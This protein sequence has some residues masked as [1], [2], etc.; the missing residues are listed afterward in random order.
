MEMEV[1]DESQRVAAATRVWNQLPEYLQLDVLA[2]LP[3]ETMEIYRKVPIET[4]EIYRKVCD[5]QCLLLCGRSS[6]GN[7]HCMA[8]CFYTWTWKV[9][10]FNISNIL[11]T[12]GSIWDHVVDINGSAAGLIF[13]NLRI[14]DWMPIVFNPYTGS[15]IR[16][17]RMSSIRLIKHRRI[18]ANGNNTYHVVALGFG[19]W[20]IL[21]NQA[22]LVEIYDS[23][24]KT[25]KVAG[26]IPWSTIDGVRISTDED[27]M[28]FCDGCFY[29]VGNGHLIP[30]RIL[31]FS[32]PAG[33][34]AAAYADAEMPIPV[35]VAPLPELLPGFEMSWVKLVTC[36]GSRLIVVAN[37][38]V[39]IIIP[40]GRLKGEGQVVLW[41]FQREGETWTWKEMSTMPSEFNNGGRYQLSEF[42]FNCIG[43]GNFVCFTLY[44]TEYMVAY[45]VMDN[46][47]SWLPACGFNGTSLAFE[48]RSDMSV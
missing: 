23:C 8:F 15:S 41:E 30:W 47:W 10:A 4:M 6:P 13:A 25:W 24:H 31:G 46:S 11:D 21:D 28:V 3:I 29:F 18:I 14:N 27:R 42:L 36:T 7:N 43:V 9:P 22:L 45:N 19:F 5:E 1:A 38:H 44:D 37:I 48:P 32:V 16:L 2:R 34:N 12:N 40:G 39:P 20:D 17:P 35:L 33:S 26:Y